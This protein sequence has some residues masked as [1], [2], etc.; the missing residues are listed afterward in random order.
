[1]SDS[2]FAHRFDVAQHFLDVGV[3]RLSRGLELVDLRHRARVPS[4]RVE[5]SASRSK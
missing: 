1:M 2:S 5:E 3:C 4:I